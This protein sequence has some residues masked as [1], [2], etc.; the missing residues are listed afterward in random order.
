MD[1]SLLST[2]TERLRAESIGD[3][4][5]VE[6]REVFEYSTQ[7]VE[8]VT[9]LKVVRAAQ[10]VHALDLLCRSGL[11]IDM[12]AIYRCV[13]DCNSEVYF[14]L[15][16]YP[17]QSNDVQKFVKA[18]FATTIDS[19]LSAKTEYVLT[20]KIHSAVARVI[21]CM[22]QHE[23]TQVRLLSV[24]KTF[25]GYTHANYSN[26]MEIYGGT[27]PDLSFNVAGVPS[28]YQR[29]THMKIVEQAYLSVI[30]SLAYIAQKLGR[31]TLFMEIWSHH[32]NISI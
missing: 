29:N 25:C 11:F 1:L 6:S 23:S 32:E 10:G 3:P 24:Y 31:N 7:S 26:I 14:L 5:W 4:E 21:S 2:L 13:D 8:V 22:E 9:V 18:F 16:N 20:K 15:E 12:G 17:I 27:H 28:V 30:Y 19:D